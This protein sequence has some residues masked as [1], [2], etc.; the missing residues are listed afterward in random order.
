MSDDKGI[1]GDP[2]GWLTS[3]PYE[4]NCGPELPVGWLLSMIATGLDSKRLCGVGELATGAESG[5][6]NTLALTLVPYYPDI[7]HE[8]VEVPGG[9]PEITYDW[10]AFERA[11]MHAAEHA[12]SRYIPESEE[13]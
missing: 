8:W 2:E 4:N 1:Q 3:E 13:E 7:V 10:R 5:W 11:V 12:L 6:Y 9:E